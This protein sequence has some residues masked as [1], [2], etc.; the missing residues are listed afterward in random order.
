MCGCIT[1]LTYIWREPISPS[2]ARFA[3]SSPGPH[4]SCLPMEPLSALSIAT[5]V[6]HFL[7]FTGKVVSGTWHI[8]RGQPPK[9]T[10]A[11]SDVASITTSLQ[12]VTRSLQASKKVCSAALVFTSCSNIQASQVLYRSW[13]ITP[14]T[15]QPTACSE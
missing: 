8:Y 10:E 15:T 6:I 12:R 2:L 4:K 7:D 14:H 9:K 5:A 11:N 13:R 3:P 1:S